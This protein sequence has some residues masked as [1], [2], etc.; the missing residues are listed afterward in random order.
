MIGKAGADKLRAASG[1]SLLEFHV[2]F[3]SR[4]FWGGQK[5]R[6]GPESGVNTNQNYASEF[7]IDMNFRKRI[8]RIVLGAVIFAAIILAVVVGLPKYRAYMNT[9]H[10]T[11]EVRLSDGK[12]ILVKRAHLFNRYGLEKATLSFSLPYTR[13]RIVWTGTFGRGFQSNV[14]PIAL[15]VV[16]EIPYLVTYP[17]NCFGYNRWGRS[18]LPYV[19]FEYENNSWKRINLNKYPRKISESNLLITV[20]KTKRSLYL[21]FGTAKAKQTLWSNRHMSS[22]AIRKVNSIVHNRFMDHL[23]YIKENDDPFVSRCADLEFY[24]GAWISRGSSFGKK[25]ID[26]VHR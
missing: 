19:F 23:I 8:V 2:V 7:A 9:V 3:Q 11:E 4:E 26:S 14:V 18:N 25:I 10:W 6:P 16:N 24:K 21:W 12:T 1:L 5:A 22:M 17:I 13:E 15:D 20:N